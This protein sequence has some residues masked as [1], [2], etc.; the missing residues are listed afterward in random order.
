MTVIPAVR[1]TEPD[2]RLIDGRS[3]E[4]AALYL[5]NVTG[6]AVVDREVR[7][8]AY[9]LQTAPDGAILTNRYVEALHLEAAARWGGLHLAV[10]TRQRHGQRQG[11]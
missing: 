10:A 3:R 4:I 8:L 11:L 9:A 1:M 2:E 5:R 7:C 6:C